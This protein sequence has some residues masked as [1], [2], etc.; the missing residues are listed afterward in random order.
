MMWRK[1]TNISLRVRFCAIWKTTKTRNRIS[2]VASVRY[3]LECSTNLSPGTAAHHL[4]SNTHQWQRVRV[5]RTDDHVTT[6]GSRTHSGVKPESTSACGV[7]TV[8]HAHTN[9]AL[10]SESLVPPRVKSSSGDGPFLV[11]L[12]V[13]V[14]PAELNPLNRFGSGGG[15]DNVGTAAP[16]AEAPILAAP[17]LDT[18][19]PSPPPPPRRDVRAP[20]LSPMSYFDC[21]G[22]SATPARILNCSAVLQRNARFICFSVLMLDIRW[23]P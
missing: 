21:P 1:P 4:C 10:D 6:L 15:P 14:D 3:I 17:A 23:P 16:G 9:E 12:A 5:R 13:L 2:C 11:R 7:I 19:L 8:A 20:G 18:P 22:L